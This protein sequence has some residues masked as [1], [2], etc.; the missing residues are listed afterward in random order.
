MT[1]ARSPIL[2][3][4]VRFDRGNWRPWSAL[5]CMIGVAIPL[6]WATVA[7]H[8]AL[9]VLASLGALYA[10][11]TSF[12]GIYLSRLRMMLGTTLTMTVVTFIG[13]S[14][15][16]HDVSAVIAVLVGAFLLALVS[17]ASASAN[18]I[19]IQ[20]TGV[21]VVL[22]G[23]PATSANP[24]G[25]ALLVLG[26]GLV[27]TLLLTVIW[28][29]DPRA[30]ERRAVAAVFVSLAHFLD[31]LSQNPEPAIPD[32]EPFQEARAFM[33]EAR[34]FHVLP[35]HA[36]LNHALRGAEALRAALVG[37]ARCDS[38]MREDGPEG[39]AEAE[40]TAEPVERSF[41]EIAERL[42]RGADLRDVPLPPL[43]EAARPDWAE[44][45]R[46]I[47]L[48]RQI[49]DEI[50]QPP[51]TETPVPFAS[52]LL[53]AVARVTKLPDSFALRSLSAQHALRYSL[54]VGL[55]MALCRAWGVEH[56]YWLPLT[57]GLVLRPDYATT[58]TRGIARLVGTVAGVLMASG[59][60]LL[61][62]PGPT[63]FTALM[64]LAGWL[65]C[66]LYLA[67]YAAYTSAI[68]LYVVYSVAASGIPERTAGLQRLEATMAG[69]VLALAANLAWPMWQSRKVQGVLRDALRAQIEYG[70]GVVALFQGAP[71]DPAEA[72]RHWARSLRVEA[73]RM[74]EAAQIEPS[75]GRVHLP[76]WAPDI[77]AALTENAAI[78]LSLHAEALQ[79]R[80]G[81][82]LGDAD[83]GERA[84]AVLTAAQRLAASL[85]EPPAE[86]QPFGAGNVK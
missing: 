10:G 59:V 34:K 63:A 81:R 74:V 20:G 18:T 72:K 76:Q 21:L 8:S 61:L 28:P 31:R 52:G 19:A 69:V 9:G 50:R 57:A 73:E 80:A 55:A 25:N 53:S 44:H 68:T 32:S 67:N 30:P 36:V 2:R 14:V 66:A 60:A 77:L 58:L 11:M 17:A 16:A 64:L 35:D 26:G 70:R 5:R 23:I 27:Q 13:S 46:W 78:M 42:R 43:E 38:A 71:D 33:D 39:V 48:L 37:F 47:Q 41:L 6:I 1:L 56:A 83:A 62:H 12:R 84:S 79:Q 40:R 22:S 45:A 7:G 65:A 15:S 4:L 49:V 54:A 85:E 86:D 51:P 82:L 29:V 24:L 75:W 3:G